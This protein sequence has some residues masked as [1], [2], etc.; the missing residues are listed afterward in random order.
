[1][2][3]P[4]KP[5]AG[6]AWFTWPC[7]LQITGSLYKNGI[8]TDAYSDTASFRPSASAMPE[9]GGDIL[10]PKASRRSSGTYAEKDSAMVEAMGIDP[11]EEESLHRA[12]SARQVSMIAVR[13]ALTILS[14]LTHWLSYQAWWCGRY[15]LDHWV[16]NCPCPWR[17]V[18]HLPW[19]F[20]CRLGV[21]H[22]HGWTGR[23]VCLFTSQKR[24]PW[25]CNT[26]CRSRIRVCSW[27]ELCI[28]V[29]SW[30]QV[31]EGTIG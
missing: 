4:V 15:R 12:L 7:Y 16:R 5:V 26:F 6:W 28:Q 14:G 30:L 27:L 29:R 24:V 18:G 10:A 23:D 9:S 31:I 21:L 20:V 19:I 1:M 2:P 3:L 13:S 25:L 17:T 22:G 8:G 11:R